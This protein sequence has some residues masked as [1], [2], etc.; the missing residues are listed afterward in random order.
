LRLPAWNHWMLD[1]LR[2]VYAPLF[3]GHNP[4]LKGKHKQNN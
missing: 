3:V 4:S 2:F 1:G